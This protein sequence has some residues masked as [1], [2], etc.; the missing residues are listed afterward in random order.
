VILSQALQSITQTLRGARIDDASVEA[1]LLLGH[2]LGISKTR[3]FTE[4]ERSLTSTET[5]RLRDLVRRRLDGEPAAYILGHCEFYGIDLNVD[6]RTLIPRPETELLVE[7]AIELARRMSRQERRTIIADIGTGCGAIAISLALALPRARI[8][9]TDISP[10]ALKVAEANCRRHGVNGRV[11]LLQGNLL[12]PLPQGV[13]VIV[14]NLPYVKDCEVAD[15]RPEI[16]DHEPTIAWAGGRD[17]LDK[18][19]E[20]LEQMRAK[21][22]AYPGEGPA[23]LLLEIGQG[24]G[25]MV[26]SLVNDCFPGASIGL[27]SDPGGVER[28]VKVGLQVG[29]SLLKE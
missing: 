20:M 28:V 29:K 6:S 8:Y 25:E 7:E 14:A 16:R 26:T 4:P 27:I 23:Y 19:R 24:Q 12:E 15:L 5:E 21:R 17:G 2:V 22:S 10:S 3:L 11:E 13:D 1:E 18:I 9:A